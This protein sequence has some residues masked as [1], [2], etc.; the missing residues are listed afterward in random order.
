MRVAT[1]QELL[2]S[3]KGG[4]IVSCQAHGNNPL[5]GSPYMAA[6]ARAAQAGGAVGIRANGGSDV[7][8]IRAAVSLPILGINKLGHEG[9]GLVITPTFASAKEVVD[10]GA[11]LVAIS[12]KREHRPDEAAFRTLIR[13]VQQELGALVMADCETYEEGLWAAE[14]GA[15]LVGT[16]Y[17]LPQGPNALYEPD[18]ALLE[19]LVRAL[20]GLPIIGEGRFWQPETVAQGLALGAHA[21]VVGTAITN[22]T[23]I[24]RRYVTAI[25]K[26]AV[27]P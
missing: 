4:L 6:V 17:A 25:S 3:M 18:L 13:A 19:Q 5:K 9:M 11:E 23:E 7:A 21:I 14:L 8:A 2:A 24:T 22:P 12:F 20:P 16:T 26:G 1:K 15:D 27:T 10:A